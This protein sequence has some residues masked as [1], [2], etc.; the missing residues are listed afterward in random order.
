MDIKRVLEDSYHDALRA[1]VMGTSPAA[2]ARAR[3]RVLVK[4][5]AAQLAAAAACAR[6]YLAYGARGQA[7]FG[8]RELPWDIC[9]YRVDASEPIQGQ[10][11]DLAFVAGALWQVAIDFSGETA[12]A[13]QAINRLNVGGAPNKLL[14]LAQPARGSDAL[15]ATLQQPFAGAGARY[16]ALLPHPADWHDT[17]AAP[18]AWQ[19]QA[20]HWRAL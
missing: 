16:V 15:L 7:H 2:L 8:A 17:R 11:A 9:I 6:A 1:L 18:A 13:L 12:G 20:E 3:Q 4:A 5:L 14:L 19:W 10:A